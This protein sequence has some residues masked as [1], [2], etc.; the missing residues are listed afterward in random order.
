M[1][2]RYLRAAQ[3]YL[4]LGMPVEA[5]QELE[6]IAPESRTLPE[7]L[8]MRFLIYS[9]IGNWEMAEAVAGH[10]AK[11]NPQSV[12]WWINWACAARR[13]KDIPAAREILLQAEGLHPDAAVVQFNLGCYACQLGDMEEAKQRVGRA[14]S[15][16][17]HFRAVALDDPDLEPLWDIFSQK[18][19]V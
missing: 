10:L 9:T 11:T 13:S 2:E 8:A 17:A 15:L 6:L 1:D 19:V 5:S 4:E 18:C 3:G 16:D 7:V 14:I 12:E